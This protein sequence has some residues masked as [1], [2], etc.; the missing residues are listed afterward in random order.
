[1]TLTYLLGICSGPNNYAL[2]QVE[3]LKNLGALKKDLRLCVEVGGQ[4]SGQTPG[5][6]CCL[7]LCMLDLV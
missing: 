6:L 2:P 5:Y 7:L 1:M 4:G 3:F